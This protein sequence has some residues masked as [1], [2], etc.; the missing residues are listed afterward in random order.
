MVDMFAPYC[1]TC[2]RR[3]LLGTRRI[4]TADL[5]E[6]SHF[7]VLLR[8]FCDTVVH[9]DN[10]VPSVADPPTTRVA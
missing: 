2:R 1:P 8:C 10:P 7:R 6:G 5:Q 9:H 4:V 3:M